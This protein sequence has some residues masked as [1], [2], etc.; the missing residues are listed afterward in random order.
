MEP[1]SLVVIG[2][3]VGILLQFAIPAFFIWL[4]YFFIKK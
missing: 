4:I 2:F 3:V 1:E